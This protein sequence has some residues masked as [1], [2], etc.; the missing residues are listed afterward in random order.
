MTGVLVRRVGEATGTE[1]RP[2]KDTWR[3]WS[4]TNQGEEA[5]SIIPP[6]TQKEESRK[7]FVNSTSD[8]HSK[9]QVHRKRLL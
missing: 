8:Y 4:T 9:S 1:G 5:E 2:C 7:H 3:R 6:Y